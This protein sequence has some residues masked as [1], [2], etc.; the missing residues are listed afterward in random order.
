MKPE[1]FQNPDDDNNAWPQ[2]QQHWA[3]TPEIWRNGA[4][5]PTQ[6]PL[7]YNTRDRAGYTDQVI[8]VDQE[9]G[10]VSRDRYRPDT[11]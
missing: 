9:V 1:D 4:R 3:R 8:R 6:H 5:T 10:D 11:L 2:E 7:I